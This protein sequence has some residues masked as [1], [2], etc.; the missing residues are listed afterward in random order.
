MYVLY[1]YTDHFYNFSNK[2]LPLQ[3]TNL[4]ATEEERPTNLVDAAT[5]GASQA[6]VIVLNVTA[7]IISYIAI[8][9]LLNSLTSFFFGLIGHDHVTFEWLLGKTLIPLAYMMGVQWEECEQVGQLIGL[10]V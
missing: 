2:I 10:K 7:N 5:R 3:L 1:V 6:T 9:A 8:V 4:R